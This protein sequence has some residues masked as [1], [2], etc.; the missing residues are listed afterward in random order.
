MIYDQNLYVEFLIIVVSKD[1]WGYS[2]LLASVLR[3]KKKKVLLDWLYVSRSIK[4]LDWITI[5]MLKA[6]KPKRVLYRSSSTG[7]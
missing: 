1:A 6:K 3:K 5:V 4:F 7:I 2:Q